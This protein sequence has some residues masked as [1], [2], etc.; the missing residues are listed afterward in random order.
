M[1]VGQ[2][3]YNPQIQ[4]SG[5]PKTKG[6]KSGKN[7]EESQFQAVVEIQITQHRNDKKEHRKPSK[8]RCSFFCI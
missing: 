1:T 3:I 2:L 8:I 4:K 7:L 6:S 5:E